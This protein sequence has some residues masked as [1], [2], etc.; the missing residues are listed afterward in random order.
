MNDK[1]LKEITE[2]ELK[3]IQLDI[4]D[5]VDNFC[6]KHNIMYSLAC[7]TLLG[8]IRHK[9]YI[10]WDDDIDIQMLRPDY[11]KLIILFKKEQH[12]RFYIQTKYDNVDI[13]YAKISTN[14]TL[15]IEEHSHNITGVNIDL[16][17]ID[18][19]KDLNDFNRRHRKVLKLY[20]WYS[21]KNFEYSRCPSF[22]SKIKLAAKKFFLSGM[23]NTDIQT[24]IEEIAQKYSIE[25]CNYLFEMVA[26]RIYKK[27]FPRKAFTNTV[28]TLF[29]KKEYHILNDYDEYLKACYEDYMKLPPKEKQVSHHNFKA[30]WKL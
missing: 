7:G 2:D 10:P 27:P 9:G 5:Y 6:Q 25:E 22:L 1:L 28:K 8:A 4:L 19:V 15:L 13:P 23:S 20:Q 3:K 17:P 21:V 12:N 29:E 11:D 14:D 18:G 16:F 26:G 30:Y 24:K